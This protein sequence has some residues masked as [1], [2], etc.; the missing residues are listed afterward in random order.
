MRRRDREKEEGI[1]D[2]Q[3]VLNMDASMEGSLVFKDP[4]NLQINGD[5]KGKL[6]AKGSLTI[7]EHANVQADIIGEI[8]V[9]AGR[10]TGQITATKE[11]RLVPPAVVEGDIQTP[12]LG[13]TP[14]AVLEGKSKMLSAQEKAVGEKTMG[15]EEVARYLEVE[16]S[17]IRQWADDRKIPVNGKGSEL[18]FDKQEIDKWIVDER[19]KL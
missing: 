16:T 13:V 15:L 3:K 10:V 17:I 11:L 19:V 8:V 7:G 2:T 5:F 18:R 6:D 4:V 12:R 9:V 14:G 1:E